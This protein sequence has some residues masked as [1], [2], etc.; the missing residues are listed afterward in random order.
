MRHVIA[1]TAATWLASCTTTPAAGP[2]TARI[3]SALRQG[4][5]AMAADDWQAA[6][7]QFAR[8]QTLA[9]S[10]DDPTQ[11]AMAALNRA[12]I[13]QRRGLP[14][15]ATLGRLAETATL[16]EGLRQQAALRWAAA[17]LRRGDAVTALRRLPT[18]P[19][20]SALA[21]QRL[22]L[23]ARIA[24]AT[25]D[26]VSAAELAHRQIATNGQPGEA[27][28]ARRLL[29]RLALLETRW[30]DA[31]T[32]AE[33]GYALD[34]AAQDSERLIEDLRLLARASEGLGQS[35]Q[36]TLYAARAEAIQQA[37]CSRYRNWRPGYCGAAN[38]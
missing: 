2:I 35:S 3:D 13:A 10:V 31:L 18:L 19:P 21:A 26:W 1:L 14:D 6:D 27:A 7:Q 37:S 23:Q 28:N 20:A 25:G 15:E 5:A 12:H 22:G 32:A 11:E 24:E 30:T 38:P 36:A 34:F 9:V 4:Q 8:A 29:A 33:A 16:P 17:A